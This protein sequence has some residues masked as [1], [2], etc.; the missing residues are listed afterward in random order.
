MK[1]T[2]RQ[3]NDRFP[4]TSACLE[5][6]KALRFADWKCPDCESPLLYKVA[7]RSVYASP[8]GKQVHPL[9]GTIFHKSSTDLRTWFL[10]IFMMTTTRSGVSAKTVERTTGVTYKTAWRMCKQIRSLMKD[11]GD[12][13]TGVV[14]VD[15]TYIGGVRKGKVGMGAAREKGGI[16]GMVERGGRMRTQVIKTNRADELIGNIQANVKRGSTIMTDELRSYTDLPYQGYP[17]H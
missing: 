8:C 9:A 14:E 3:F 16:Q 2:T 4:T 11:G 1:F 13:L 7:G 10:T 5:E 12:L 6:L 15:E 17:L